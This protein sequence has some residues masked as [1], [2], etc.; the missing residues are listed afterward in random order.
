[1]GSYGLPN[2]DRLWVCCSHVFTIVAS[3]FI[4][5]TMLLPILCFWHLYLFNSLN[6]LL[7][8]QVQLVRSSLVTKVGEITRLFSWWLLFLLSLLG[9]FFTLAF[10]VKFLGVGV[11]NFSFH[12]CKFVC[13]MHDKNLGVF[14]ILCSMFVSIL[15]W[16]F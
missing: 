2:V 5:W 7:T 9:F 10:L 12:Y 6:L 8:I 15:F 1:M 11:L 4:N 13:F 14:L 16:C 3:I